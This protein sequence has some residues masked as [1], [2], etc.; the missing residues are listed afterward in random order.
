MSKYKCKQV[1]SL[2][3]GKWDKMHESSRRV[4]ATDGLAP[5]QN[6][7]QGGGH[8]TKIIEPTEK[9]EGYRIRRLTEKECGRLM[10]VKDE[11]IEKIAKHQ[12]ASGQY[13]LYGNS[14]VV[15]VLMAIFKEMI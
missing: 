10:G 5:T 4:Y 8:E 7:S 14:I 6:T 13:K 2:Q 11:D 15:Q 9:I 1:G 12:S 3:G